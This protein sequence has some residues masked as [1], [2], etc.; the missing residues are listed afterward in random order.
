MNEVQN[1]DNSSTQQ[2]QQQQQ[3]SYTESKINFLESE[4][5]YNKM[6]EGWL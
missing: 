1:S 3:Q 6:K 4:K 2:Q 5:V